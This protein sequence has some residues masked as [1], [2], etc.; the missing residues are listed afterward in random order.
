M[1]TAHEL[2]AD[3]AAQ[4]A[5]HGALKFMG[6]KPYTPNEFRAEIAERAILA[7]RAQR[8]EPLTADGDERFYGMDLDEEDGHV[9]PFGPETHGIV[10]E[11]QGGI[12]AYCHPDNTLLIV[13]ALREATA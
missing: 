10:D 2:A 1:K 5:E 3:I 6:N 12:I 11:E 13:R 9:F 7:D 8:A 4:V